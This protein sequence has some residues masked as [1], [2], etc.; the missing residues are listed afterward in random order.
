MTNSVSSDGQTSITGQ[1][2]FPSGTAAA[3]SHTFGSDPT[4]GMYLVGT[5]KVGWSGGGVAGLELDTTRAGASQDGGLLTYGNTAILSPVGK[6]AMF[7]GASAP[8]GW[9]L[10]FGQ[11]ISRTSYP[12]LF[13]V[14]ST[15]YGAGDG[16][17]TY[18]V[19]DG[20][21]RSAFGKDDMGGAA[22]GRL[23]NAATGGIP[24]TVLGGTGGEQAHTL[25]TAEL[26][27]HSHINTLTD[28]QHTHGAHIN[29][30]TGTSAQAA[31]SLTPVALGGTAGNLLSGSNPSSVGT[32]DNA[33]T[34]ITINNANAGS[35]S[36]HNTVPPG[37]VFNMIIFAGR[38]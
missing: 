4:S 26:A 10:L 33:A 27:V 28:P 35:G 13:T 36:T 11:A 18:N 20:R 7:A 6:V 32:T 2:K 38:P 37:I 24:G 3:P 15:T 9:L 17:T 29:T 25:T 21:G 22:A 16:S 19:P 34:G 12:E 5:S 8:V 1:L 31:G 23:S 30:G 14:I